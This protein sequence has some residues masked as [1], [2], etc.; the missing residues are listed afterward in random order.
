M[1]LICS[2]DITNL[3]DVLEILNK[4]M[5][6]YRR[7]FELG[8]LLG[9]LQPTL[10]KIEV[11]HRNDVTR[12]LQECLTCWLRRIDKVDEK[13]RPT[14]DVLASALKKMEEHFVAENIIQTGML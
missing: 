14:W 11:D 1:F 5:F 13:G 6:P 9:I 3:S 7:W 2:L 8:L 10:A 4:H 12:C